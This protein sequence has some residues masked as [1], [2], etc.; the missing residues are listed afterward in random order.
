VWIRL[1]GTLP[2][3]PLMHAAALAFVSDRTLLR[4][5]ARPHSP[6]WRIR[7]A[8]SVDHALWLHRPVRFDDWVLYTCESP[9]AETGRAL[10]FGAIYTRDGKRVASVAQEGILRL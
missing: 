7:E 9:A 2:E 10:A 6:I 4:V 8:A 5:A 1:R 3:D